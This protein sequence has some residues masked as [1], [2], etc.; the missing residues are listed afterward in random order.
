MRPHKEQFFVTPP[1]S[2]STATSALHFLVRVPIRLSISSP[3]L[4]RVGP[5]DVTQ[6]MLVMTVESSRAQGQLT[7]GMLG[8]SASE[9]SYEKIKSRMRRS[10]CRRFKHRRETEK[11]TTS[12]SLT[13]DLVHQLQ[14]NKRSSTK[15]F[16]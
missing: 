11:D 6:S 14:Y 16:L 8:L 13:R 4:S 12:H 15:M 10:R 7:V 3:T 5:H 2:V 9:G 1:S